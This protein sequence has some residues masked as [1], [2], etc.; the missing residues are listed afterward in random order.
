MD[1]A[2][3]DLAVLHHGHR[4]W[5]KAKVSLQ[6]PHHAW[7]TMALVEATLELYRAGLAAG[8]ERITLVSGTCIQVAPTPA[9]NGAQYAT[10]GVQWTSLTADCVADVLENLRLADPG[11]NKAPD[12]YLIQQFVLERG[13][14]VEPTLTFATS[15][16][17]RT[18]VLDYHDRPAIE[19]SGKVFARK[20][21]R[22]RSD[23]LARSYDYGR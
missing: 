11:P 16:R 21:V 6:G 13:Y 14:A 20:L 18:K 8:M 7:G 2:N 1:S 9:E 19:D 22:G 5:L 17:S 10:P 15:H 23:L 12:A 4:P 3:S